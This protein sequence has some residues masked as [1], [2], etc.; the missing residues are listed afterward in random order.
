MTTYTDYTDSDNGAQSIVRLGGE[1]VMDEVYVDFS[2]FNVSAAD[3]LQLFNVSKGDVLI[4]SIVQVATA[5]GGTAT[6]DIGITTTDPN[7]L[8]DA[9]DLNATGVKG[10]SIPGTDALVGYKLTTDDTVDVVFDNALDA[11]KVHFRLIKAAANP[12]PA[13]DAA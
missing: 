8:D 13:S 12:N 7:G 4:S 11:A 10:V 3:V 5:E 2:V 9:V 1:L 6:C